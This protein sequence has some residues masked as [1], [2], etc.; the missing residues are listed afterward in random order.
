MLNRRLAPVRHQAAQRLRCGVVGLL[1]VCAIV[2]ASQSPA[3]AQEG[4]YLTGQLLVA[5]PEM[6]DPRFAQTII[7]MISHNE[8]GAMGLVIN[9]PLARGPISDLLKASGLE[10]EGASGEIILHYGGPVEPERA[11]VLHSKDYV[12]KGTTIVDGVL[13]VTANVEILRAIADGKGPR[14]SLFALGYA[15]WAPGQLETEMKAN[16]W[17]SIPAEEALIFDGDAKTRWERA[18]A[19]QKI[20]T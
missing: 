10:S 15:G 17:F 5:T 14:Q 2:I 3:A 12:G 9:R 19:K 1:L 6:P 13:A 16:D 20:K 4:Q 8:D 18:M 7:Y 11:F